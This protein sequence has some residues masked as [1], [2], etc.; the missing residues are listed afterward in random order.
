[1]KGWLSFYVFV[2]VFP[3]PPF[4]SF[5]FVFLP[6]SV[7]FLGYVIARTD[8]NPLITQATSTHTTK[9]NHSS[10]I[11]QGAVKVLHDSTIVNGMN[12]RI[13][14]IDLLRAMGVISSLRG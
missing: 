5:L 4:F 8:N 9:R 11:G 1:M 13:R 14:I 6:I 3:R 10:V 7:L 12:A 2:Y